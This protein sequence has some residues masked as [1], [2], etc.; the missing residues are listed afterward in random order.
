MKI[1]NQERYPDVQFLA[2]EKVRAVGTVGGSPLI[3]VGFEAGTNAPVVASISSMT[4]LADAELDPIPLY[5]LL[6]HSY[7]PIDIPDPIT[8]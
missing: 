2:E 1:L 8:P 6:S 3:L 7:D 5:E 4:A